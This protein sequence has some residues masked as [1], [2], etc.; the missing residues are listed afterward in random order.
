MIK[1][2][3]AGLFLAVNLMS[4]VQAQPQNAQTNITPFDCGEGD[5]TCTRVTGN[6]QGNHE[7][8]CT[9]IR[10]WAGQADPDQRP[11]PV[12]AW[13]NGWDQGN[14]VGQCTSNGYRPGL[15]QWAEDGPYVVV[16]ANQWSA[17][18]TDVLACLEYVLATEE[19]IDPD[20]TGL[21]GHSQGGG[22][23]IKAGNG[24][25]K[26]ANITASIAMNP[27]G[28]DWVDAGIQDGPMLL[29]GGTADTT[30]PVSSFINVWEEVQVNQGG[31]LAVRKGGT[32]NNDAWGSYDSGSTMSCEDASR[33]N[34]GHFQEVS[35][36]W[37]DWHLNGTSD[38]QALANTLDDPDTGT[39]TSDFALDH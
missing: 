17:K 37:W 2:I 20:K 38:A 22:A 19:G 18:D 39:W 10:P 5:F 25:K 28:P 12:I 16:A 27:Y 31:V 13:A 4:A 9:I 26:R 7:L 14:V 11:Y 33:E 36:V 21:A 35:R 24:L 30:T 29:L 15:K 23:V 6:S 1:T 32:H 3:F 8:D 34:F